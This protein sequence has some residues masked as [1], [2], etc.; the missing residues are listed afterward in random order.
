VVQYASA[1]FG[2]VGPVGSS[3]FF[4]LRHQDQFYG[5]PSPLSNEYYFLGAKQ[6]GT[7]TDRSL[8]TSAE[9]KKT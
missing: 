4:S 9:V 6:P 1:C 8:L 2:K 5:P 7:E 3:I